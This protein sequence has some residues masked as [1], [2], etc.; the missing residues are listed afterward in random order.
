LRCSDQ[1]AAE[2][3]SAQLAAGNSSSTQV[4]GH[5]LHGMY[6]A[7]LAAAVAAV[8]STA[9]AAA[10]GAAVGVAAVLVTGSSHVLGQC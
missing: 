8:A 2:R 6:G 5:A 7:V 3:T 4:V 9:A 10:A 1:S